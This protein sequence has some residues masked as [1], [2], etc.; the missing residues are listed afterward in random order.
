MVDNVFIYLFIYLFICVLY[1]IW[2][3]TEYAYVVDRWQCHTVPQLHKIIYKEASQVH[4]QDES[5]TWCTKLNLIIVYAITKLNQVT[6]DYRSLLLF[7]TF[8]THVGYSRSH[9]YIKWFLFD[10]DSPMARLNILPILWS[11]VSYTIL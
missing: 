10:F 11:I 4:V 2:L 8:I 9:E 7:V 6:S 1:K 3:E 5:F